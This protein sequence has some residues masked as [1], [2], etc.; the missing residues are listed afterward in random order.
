MSLEDVTTCNYTTA[1]C[2]GATRELKGKR[3]RG[4]SEERVRLKDGRG[5]EQERE[6]AALEVRMALRERGR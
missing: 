4:K 1:N 5:E 2:S 3:R 6:R